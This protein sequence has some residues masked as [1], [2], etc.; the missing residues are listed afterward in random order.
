M[1]F[2]ADLLEGV[3]DDRCNFI[4]VSIVFLQVFG[5]FQGGRVRDV[6]RLSLCRLIKV[7]SPVLFVGFHYSMYGCSFN[8]GNIVVFCVTSRGIGSW[9]YFRPRILVGVA[10]R[11]CFICLVR[12]AEFY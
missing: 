2:I 8:G 6:M 11:R 7:C 3:A 12:L 9:L 10:A 1:Q 5:V 4:P